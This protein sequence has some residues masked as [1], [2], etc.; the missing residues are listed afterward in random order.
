LPFSFLRTRFV[1]PPRSP[2]DRIDPVATGAFG[3]QV[4]ALIQLAQ[5]SNFSQP[6][7]AAQIPP[8][9]L[10][11]FRD[12]PQRHRFRQQRSCHRSPRGAALAMQTAYSRAGRHRS[13][14]PR[15]QMRAAEA[16]VGYRPRCFLVIGRDA[17]WVQDCGRN[18]QAGCNHSAVLNIYCCNGPRKHTAL[19]SELSEQFHSELS[20]Q[21]CR[22][23]FAEKSLARF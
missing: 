1:A 10:V 17:C 16:L 2:S 20:E 8:I 18:F 12:T 6:G 3:R 21:P 9:K 19:H 22:V 4:A 7:I 11:A 23:P 14:V 15:R 13:T 5:L